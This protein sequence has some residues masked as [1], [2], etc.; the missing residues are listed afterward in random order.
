MLGGGGKLRIRLLH[1]TSLIE[2]LGPFG[3][4]SQENPISSTQ[5]MFKWWLH[6]LPNICG[7]NVISP[8]HLSELVLITCDMQVGQH[9]ETA[10]CP[11][12]L[13]SDMHSSFTSQPLQMHFTVAVLLEALMS[14]SL[15]YYSDRMCIS[16]FNLHSRLA[17]LR[18]HQ[19]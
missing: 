10:I 13:P 15:H 16:Y 17:M 7:S 5:K 1:I 3:Q 12:V 6:H 19:H 2:K 11:Q 4:T 18:T 14:F 8:V 9:V